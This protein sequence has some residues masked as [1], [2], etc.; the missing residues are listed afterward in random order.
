MPKLDVFYDL[1]CPYCY[2]GLASFASLLPDYPQ[3]E[4]VWR[5]VEAHPKG[6]EPWHKPYADVAVM[7]AFFARDHGVDIADYNA[8]VFDM[9]YGRHQ[10]VDDPQAIV[11]AVAAPLGLDGDAMLRA[12]TDG[13]YA[14]A[15]AE[16]NAYAY[17]ANKVWAVPTFVC[18][19]K[20]LDAQEGVG[21]SAE[22]LAAL[23]Q[24][25]YA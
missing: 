19:D 10:Q 14:A 18:G 23:L 17:E 21:V 5:P 9:Y 16:A 20:R 15:L 25:C 12:L 6:E 13:T 8:C 3:A 4:I 24:A 1:T 2:R 7:G 22:Q 11:D